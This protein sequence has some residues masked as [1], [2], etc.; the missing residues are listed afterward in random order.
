MVGTVAGPGAGP[1]L[2]LL[3]D[4]G[5]VGPS[6]HVVCALAEEDRVLLGG[7]V[8]QEHLH[9]GGRRQVVLVEAPVAVRPVERPHAGVLD[10]AQ[11][12]HGP[13]PG[14]P[15]RQWPHL[16][17]RDVRVGGGHLQVG[18]VLVARGRQDRAP[19]ADGRDFSLR[20]GHAA[21]VGGQPL[22][23]RVPAWAGLSGPC[24]RA[25]RG[26]VRHAD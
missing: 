20:Q 17:D 25:G 13:A 21:S 23:R 24:S 5:P 7:Q 2:R 26:G 18:A 16:D 12:G 9:V 1:W 3:V 22:Q 11:P 8:V 10:V 15:V 6:R 4:G 14:P 19:A